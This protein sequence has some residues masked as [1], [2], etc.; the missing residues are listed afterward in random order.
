M[1][2]GSIAND[3]VFGYVRV[4][5]ENQLENYSI[6]EQ[7]DRLKAYCKAKGLTLLKTYTD[8]GYSGGNTNRPALQELLREIKMQ[9]VSAVVVYK[10]DRLSRNQKD[11]LTLIE[12]EFLKHN[13]DFI[14]INENFDTSS[15][16][17]RAMIGILSIFAQLEKD[18]ITERFLMGRIGRGKAGYF[19]GGGNAPF[20]Y[21]YQ[22]GDLVVDEY[23]A[24]QVRAVFDEF[25]SGKSMNAIYRKM[26]S[27]YGGTWSAGKARNILLNSVYVGKIKFNRVEYEG[28]HTPIVSRDVFDTAG[29]LLSSEDR[30]NAKTFPQKTPFRAGYLLSGL[31]Y[32]A[33]CGARYSANHGYYKCYSRAKSSAGMVRDP[34]CRNTHWEIDALD[35]AVVRSIQDLFQSRSL[36]EDLL[37]S[38]EPSDRK[39]D[40]VETEKRIRAVDTQISRLIDLYQVEGLPI[41]QIESKAKALL[42][43]KTYLEQCLEASEQDPEQKRLRFE[44]AQKQFAREF[45]N[46]PLEA[47]RL[48]VGSLI[49]SIEMDCEHV[50][51][52]WRI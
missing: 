48:L 12:D 36:L 26:Q 4:S 2:D 42:A 16:F 38:P 11:T 5:T 3:C 52:R 21:V 40:R 19:H 9:P 39:P 33:H 15:P 28:K 35:R 20:G 29:I 1:P 37:V 25:L 18:Q 13:V 8:G 41:D 49:A 17:G 34:N 14:S 32:C 24:M 45:E 22:D 27:L 51:I 47:R 46:A 6:E 43:E 50:S 10:L 23:A 30:E 31:V 7:T 44:Q